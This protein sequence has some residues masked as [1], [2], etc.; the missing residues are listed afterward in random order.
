MTTALD[1]AQKLTVVFVPA[2]AYQEQQRLSY[3]GPFL[4]PEEDI[5]FWRT[6]VSLLVIGAILTLVAALFWRIR[7][8]RSRQDPVSPSA[9]TE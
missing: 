5:G 9:S 4:V 7:G 1:N 6:T 8:Q 2:A 3:F